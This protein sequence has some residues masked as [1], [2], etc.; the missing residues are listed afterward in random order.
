[1]NPDDDRTKF[2]AVVVP[3]LADAHAF[4]RWIMRDRADA[5]DIVQEACIRAFRG[6]HGFSGTNGRAWLLTIVRNTAFTVLKQKKAVT[7]VGLDD[8][9]ETDRLVVEHGGELEPQ[10]SPE[11]A[12]IAADDGAKLDS[13][14]AALPPEF[15]EVIVLRDIQGLDYRDIAE[16]TGSPIGTVMSRLARGRQKLIARMKDDSF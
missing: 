7:L 4:A 11:T 5:E 6:L 8:L 12:A 1:L 3:Y 14:M 10:G 16:I 2:V 9:N 15:R 13:A